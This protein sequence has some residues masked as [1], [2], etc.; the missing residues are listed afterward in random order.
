MTN[1]LPSGISVRAFLAIDL[2]EEIKETLGRI[3]SRLKNLLRGAERTIRW[4]RPS[5][6]HL[7]LQFFGDIPSE[8]V[9]LIA[10]VVKKKHGRFLAFYV[11]SRVT[12]RI[13]SRHQAPGSLSRT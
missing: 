12:W 6:I 13:S 3:Q 5:L 7:T 4:T 10:A 1:E 2:P 8:N 11:T 9:G